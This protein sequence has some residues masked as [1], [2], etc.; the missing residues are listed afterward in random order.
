[1]RVRV[2]VCVHLSADWQRLNGIDEVAVAT[3][4]FDGVRIAVGGGGGGGDGGGGGIYRQQQRLCLMFII[5]L[6]I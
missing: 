6:T 2:C 3:G 1:M 4:R 5:R